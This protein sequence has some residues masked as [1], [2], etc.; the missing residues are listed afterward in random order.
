MSFEHDAKVR[1][2]ARAAYVIKIFTDENNA[3]GRRR[4]AEGSDGIA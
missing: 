3:T 2:P 1:S 4:I